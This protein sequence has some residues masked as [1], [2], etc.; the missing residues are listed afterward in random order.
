MQR[1]ANIAQRCVQINSS[2]QQRFASRA[3]ARSM[4]APVFWRA[5]GVRERA[6]RELPRRRTVD[7]IA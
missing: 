7:S 2:R 5:N 1:F 4:R 3:F 6:I